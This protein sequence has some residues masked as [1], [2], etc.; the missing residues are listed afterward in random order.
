MP[1][2]APVSLYIPAEGGVY[3]GPYYASAPALVADASGD[4]SGETAAVTGYIDSIVFDNGASSDTFTITITNT[5]TSEVIYTKSGLTGGAVV[6]P[7]TVE[8]KSEDGTSLTSRRRHWLFNQTLTITISA[9][10]EGVE[11]TCIA[12]TTPN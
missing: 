5:A 12:Y 9:A 6:R 11:F 1:A 10:T 2:P 4:A 3:Y 8:H 7:V